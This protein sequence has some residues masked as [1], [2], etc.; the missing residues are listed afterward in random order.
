VL[1]ACSAGG[2][3]DASAPVAGSEAAP[4]VE[5]YAP[6]HSATASGTSS[7][8]PERG[9]SAAVDANRPAARVPAVTPDSAPGPAPA[10]SP[11]PPKNVAPPSARSAEA[12]DGVWTPFSD[13]RTSAGAPFFYTTKLHPHPTS[14][15][16]TLTLV[17]I[18][19]G[20]VRL[21]FMPGVED[22]GKQA[23]PFEPGL[24]PSAERE[25]TLAAFNGGFMPRHGR[26]GMQLGATTIVPPREP[27]CT[28]A[29]FDDGVR[30]RSWSVLAA[31]AARPL[32][33]RQTPPCLLE[34][35]AVH[36]LLM[37]GLDKAWA[38]H[39][40]GVV[41]RRRS[42]IGLNRAANVLFYAVGVEAPARL[43]AEGLL[44]AG[45]HDAAELDINWNWTRFLTFAKNEDG[46]LRVAQS[47]VDVQYSNR[48][49][50][51]RA[52]ERDFFYLVRR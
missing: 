44:A 37:K 42:A 15:F 26:W 24:V 28:L 41:T 10:E 2:K 52:S 14:R 47:L 23:V 11:F 32:A 3:P 5:S 16:V 25:R 22:V 49:Y 38:G 45:A 19:L 17:A 30:L 18:D 21:G 39:T 6:A 43:L 20:A 33:L 12:G 51:E 29:L 1:L 46:A 8:P 50:V 7:A 40:P 36:P 13:A 34:Q 4:L 9:P 48:A 27:G 35:G 31:D